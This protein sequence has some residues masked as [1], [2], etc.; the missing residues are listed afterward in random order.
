MISAGR[1]CLNIATLSS[2]LCARVSTVMFA[3]AHLHIH[4][5]IKWECLLHTAHLHFLLSRKSYPNAKLK[6]MP[7][8]VR[9]HME[10]HT[11]LYAGWVCMFVAF[12]I[13]QKCTNWQ[14]HV[15]IYL[16]SLCG[17]SL[18]DRLCVNLVYTHT[19][20]LYVCSCTKKVPFF[21]INVFDIWHFGLTSC[22]REAALK[23]LRLV[24]TN[25]N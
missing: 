25:D 23:L 22:V 5:Y 24:H 4:L 13:C 3:H 14:T 10:S 12:F 1:S 6:N 8:Y 20:L 18:S 21:Y 11:V 17:I 9:M 7:T 15:R 16:E 2:C 19:H